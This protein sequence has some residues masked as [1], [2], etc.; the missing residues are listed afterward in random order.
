MELMIKRRASLFSLLI[1]HPANISSMPIPAL[2]AESQSGVYKPNDVYDLKWIPPK[3]KLNKPARYIR[4]DNCLSVLA[5]LFTIQTPTLISFYTNKRSYNPG[6][7]QPISTTTWWCD[8][9]GWGGI[10]I[11]LSLPFK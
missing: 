8:P 2:N 7:I 9:S 6:C 4:E 1:N 5:L 11:S 10:G 3:N